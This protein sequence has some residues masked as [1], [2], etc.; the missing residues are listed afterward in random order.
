VV[1]VTAG[2]VLALTGLNRGY[3]A[4]YGTPVGQVVLAAVLGVFAIAFAWLRHL[5]NVDIPGRFLVAGPDYPSTEAVGEAG[6][7]P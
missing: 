4:P 7:R 1:G 6:W 3:L 5:S 2:F